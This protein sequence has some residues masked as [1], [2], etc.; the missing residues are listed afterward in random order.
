M[1]FPL[2]REPMQVVT[3]DAL[4]LRLTAPAAVNC[5]GYIEFE[6]S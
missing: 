5:Q 1:Q 3:A 6:E 4:C 2:G